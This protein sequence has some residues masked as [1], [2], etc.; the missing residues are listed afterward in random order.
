MDEFARE[1]K[2]MSTSDIMLILDDQLDLYSDEEISILRKEL[3]SRPSN[4]VELEERERERLE[5][6]QRL[7]EL[8]KEQETHYRNKINNLKNNGIEGYY[9][10]KV[11]SLLDERGFFNSQSGKV[12]I[13]T[14]TYTL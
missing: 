13:E 11:I 1:V 5:E 2:Q 14:M 7:E 4:A 3:N 6:I 12:D 8:R 10:Y 9:E